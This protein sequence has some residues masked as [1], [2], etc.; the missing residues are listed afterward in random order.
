MGFLN[1]WTTWYAKWAFLRPRHFANRGPHYATDQWPRAVSASKWWHRWWHPKAKELIGKVHQLST[2]S[3]LHPH[4]MLQ[5]AA[6][7][8]AHPQ[9]S[10][11]TPD[12]MWLRTSRSFKLSSSGTF[13]VPP[14]TMATQ[15]WASSRECGIGYYVTNATLANYSCY[16]SKIPHTL[17]A[18]TSTSSSSSLP[19]FTLPLSRTWWVLTC[20][21]SHLWQ[22]SLCTAPRYQIKFSTTILSA[23][24]TYSRLPCGLKFSDSSLNFIR[25]YGGQLAPWLAPSVVEVY[26]ASSYSCEPSW[27]LPPGSLIP[28]LTTSSQQ[29][30]KCLFVSATAALGGQTIH[31]LA[32]VKL[33]VAGNHCM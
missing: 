27:L 6:S 21:F 10:C 33:G 2:N 9:V 26:L 7:A 20:S 13:F 1:T 32:L 18:P 15:Y 5:E 4:P 8:K 25:P 19:R 24:V 16:T 31:V 12:T 14:G 30:P 17:I 3:H 22:S 23:P 11:A 29:D 28:Y